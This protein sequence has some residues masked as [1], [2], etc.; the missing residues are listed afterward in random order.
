MKVVLIPCGESEW[1]GAGRLLGRADVSPG[2]ALREQVS[3]WVQDLREIGVT[4]IFHSPDE[5]ATKT[6]KLLATALDVTVKSDAS[7]HEV[8]L[9]LWSG[10]TESEL[11]TR[12]AKA[13][14]QLLESPLNV[15]PPQGEDLGSAA[16]RLEKGLGK[17]FRKDGRPVALVLR[18]VAL[19]LARYAL[20]EADASKVWGARRVD[21]PL[22]IEHNG[23]PAPASPREA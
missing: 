22:V 3:P 20:G 7:L 13:H 15:R 9:G 17:R 10:L 1:R 21:G 11:K 4:R 2:D 16:Q 12:Y 5:L 19:A 8:D 18:P 14:R 23:Q 6:A